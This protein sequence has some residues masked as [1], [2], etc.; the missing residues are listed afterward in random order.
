[1]NTEKFDNL[2]RSLLLIG[3]IVGGASAI[4]ACADEG[5]IEEIGETVDEAADE[6]DQEL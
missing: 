3:A 1:M 5:P 6:I 2:I 4:S